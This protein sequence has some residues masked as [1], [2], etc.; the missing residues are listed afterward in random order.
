MEAVDINPKVCC[1]VMIRVKVKFLDLRRF[2]LLFKLSV[3]NFQV[4]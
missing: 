3:F 4:L 1:V 2:I